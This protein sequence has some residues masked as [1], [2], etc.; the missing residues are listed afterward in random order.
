MEQ[1]FIEDKQG[2][3]VLPITHVD[4]VRDSNGNTISSIMGTF[5]DGVEEIKSTNARGL[6]YALNQFASGTGSFDYSDTDGF[7]YTPD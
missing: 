1:V 3:K 2:N 6:L 7:T 5:E 4:A